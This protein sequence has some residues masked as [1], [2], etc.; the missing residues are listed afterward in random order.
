M[1][2]EFGRQ[3]CGSLDEAA[4]REWLVTDG[5]GGYAMG[6]V[7]GL[8]TCR[9]HGLLMVAGS[10]ANGTGDAG[11]SRRMLGLAALDATLVVGDR[12]IRLATDEWAGGVVDPVGYRDIESFSLVD[13]VPRWR[14]VIGDVVLEREIAMVHGRPAVAVRHRLVRAS[15][16]VRIEITPLCTWRDG[17]SDRRA[18][19]D[20]TIETTSDGF[21]FEHAYRVRGPEW[22]PGG[23]WYR[24]VRGTS[25][26]RARPLRHR[27]PLGGGD[28]RGDALTR[29]LRRRGRVGGRPQLG[30]TGCRR[31]RRRH[32][33]PRWPHRG[34]RARSDDVDAILARAADQFIVSTA[35]GPSVVAGYPWF[36][37][38]SRDT[39]TS[40][41]GLFLATG[42]HEE[43]RD[44][45]LRS[46]AT[47]SEGMLANTADAGGLEYNTADGTLWFIH[48]VGRHVAITGDLDI[49]AKLN[50]SLDGIIDAHSHGTRFGIKVD[51]SDGLL[52]QGAPGWALTWMDARV[53]GQPVTQRAG[54]AVE[55]NALWINALGTITDLGRRLGRHTGRWESLYDFARGSFVKRFARGDHLLDVV[56]T[57]GPD[58]GAIRPNQLLAISLPFGPFNSTVTADNQV[59]EAVVRRCRTE[60]VT[61]LGLRSLSPN[62]PGYTGQHRG[63]PAERDHV[64][65]E[66]TVWPWLIGPFVDAAIATGDASP[67]IDG[68]VAHLGEWGLGSVSETADGDAPYGATG[69]PFQAW[70]VAELLRARRALRR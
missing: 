55:I 7:A 18:G 29:R 51:P 4:S 47:L 5:L 56:G 1:I 19:A 6:T 64:Y 31:D 25:R 49:L 41:E 54:K 15:S 11:V 13:G 40:Y 37:E 62:D 28:V 39:M 8:R 33:S 10:A 9:Y 20:P 30:A 52:Q 43:G 67:S 23:S 59:A 46:A 26:S 21:V 42:R 38:W 61:S 44:L 27:R 2:I 50:G 34:D 63:G 65:H 14:W 24:G 45:L 48:A 12:H 57:T 60:L 69:C 36:G 17:H 53:D 3:V 32:A 70:S 68:L 66:G 35:T 22:A 58:D 16:P